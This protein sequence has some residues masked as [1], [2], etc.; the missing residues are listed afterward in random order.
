MEKIRS[1]K[2]NNV[3]KINTDNGRY[4][5]KQGPELSGERD[6]LNWLD[7]KLLVP[8]V[9]I[10]REKE[11]RDDLLMT[12]VEGEDLAQ[13][14]KIIPK[15]DLVNFLATTLRLVH[16]IDI[17]DCPFEK[18]EKGFVFTHGDACLPNFMFQNGKLSGIIDLGDAMIGDRE[19]DLA[20]A[21]WS[22]D[23]NFGAGLGIPFLQA[24]GISDP[25]ERDVDR[26]IRKYESNW[27]ER[28]RSN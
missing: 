16:S 12:C 13:L 2:E 8:R 23:F 15:E 3:L 1:A 6:R 25:S 28:F 7:G 18:I 11:G 9:V 22:L 20:A 4:I 17:S 24:Y 14:S 5:L 26:L 19:I 21:V 27:S 10:W